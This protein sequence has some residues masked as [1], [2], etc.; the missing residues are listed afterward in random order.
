M[1]AAVIQVNSGDD[2][3]A[4]LAAA[5]AIMT[6]AVDQ[7]AGLLALPE[8]FAFMSEDGDAKIRHR[9]DP[10]DSPSL[11]FLRHFAARH[12]VW[13]LG[14]SIAMRV[15]DSDKA[16]N[17]SFLIDDHGRI[18][19]RYDKIHLFDVNLG[20]GEPYRESDRI[21]PGHEPVTAP[22]PFGIIG[23]SVCYDLRFP[24]LYRAL[25][26]AGATILAVPAA[27]TLTTGPDHW[28]LL[29]R[30]RAVENFSYVLAPGQW[31]RHPGGRRTYGHSMVVDPW[32]TVTARHPDGTGFVLAELDPER[33][34]QC[35]QRIPCLDHRVLDIT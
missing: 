1:R 14:G 17:S 15:P 24:E 25:S 10:D 13:I 31:G 19:A 34:D 11:D 29:L 6:R 20:Q 9:E 26:A 7:G 21:Q 35:R 27:F 33:V 8:S 22:T 4:N 2:R 5:G 16:T 32:G 28:E 30:A 12:R 23:L 3:A 18:R